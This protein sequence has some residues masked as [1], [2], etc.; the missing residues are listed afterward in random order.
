MGL[1][2]TIVD[3]REWQNVHLSRRFLAQCHSP[4]SFVLYLLR[5]NPGMSVTILPEPGREPFNQ[6]KKED[7][8][9]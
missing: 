9:L 4:G 5:F 8:T 1:A 6:S 3:W 2:R 7:Q